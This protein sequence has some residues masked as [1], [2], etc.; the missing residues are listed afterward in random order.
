MQFE[1]L[2]DFE[3]YVGDD[4]FVLGY[5]RGFDGGHELAIWKRGSIASQPNVDLEKLPKILVDTA[6]REGMSGAPVIARR[7]GLIIPRGVQGTP[8]QFTGLELIG[9]AD[10]FLGV[11]SGR[12]GD[13]ELGVQ[14]GI[15]WKARVLE[16]IIVGQRIGQS[17]Y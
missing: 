9:Q 4:V 15:V 6:T 8:G 11:Y 12:I 7:R 13:D 14:L 5:P 1:G 10:T 16:E 17:P 3:P 2:T